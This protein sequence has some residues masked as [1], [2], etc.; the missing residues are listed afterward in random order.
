MHDIVY[1]RDLKV[2]TVIGIFAWERAIRQKVSIDLEMASDVRRAAATDTIAD[3]LDY[4][5]IAKRVIQFVGDSEFQLVETL[6]ERLAELLLREYSIPW[7]RL[8]VSK[9][10]AI[11]GAHDVG[12]VIERGR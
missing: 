4:K 12:V 6:A 11:R 1:L 5:S 9:P 10:G 8:R 3:A 7:V 2:A